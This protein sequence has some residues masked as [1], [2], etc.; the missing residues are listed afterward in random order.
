[1]SN[2]TELTYMQAIDE[3]RKDGEAWRARWPKHCTKCGGWGGF[4]F[5]ESHGMPGPG[6]QMFDECCAHDDLRTCHRCSELGLQEDGSGAC[7]HCGWVYGEDGDP[8]FNCCV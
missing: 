6:E 7:S 8:S 4:T 1:M 3:I 2:G 5:Y